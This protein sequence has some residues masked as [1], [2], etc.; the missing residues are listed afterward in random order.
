MSLVIARGDS[1]GD[2]MMVKQL[3]VVSQVTRITQADP[4]PGPA[5]MQEEIIQNQQHLFIKKIMTKT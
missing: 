2:K 4:G 5:K 3:L 1:I